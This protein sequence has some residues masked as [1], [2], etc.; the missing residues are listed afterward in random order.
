MQCFMKQM[1]GSVIA[2]DV[3][4]ASQIHF[5]GGLITNLRL[6]RN[7]LS[8]MRDDS[9]RSATD[10]SDFDLPILAADVTFI[11]HLTT[12]FNVETGLG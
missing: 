4:A 8:N 6:T 2:H 1:C 9:C 5:G 11:I 12:G 3:M 7:H 10:S